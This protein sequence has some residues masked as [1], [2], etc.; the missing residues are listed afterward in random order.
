MR[1]PE[2]GRRRQLASLVWL[3]DTSE[4]RAGA[5]AALRKNE[6]EG[7]AERL[8]RADESGSILVTVDARGQ[9]VDVGVARDWRER[10]ELGRFAGALFEAYVAAVKASFERAAL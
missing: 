7:Q 6:D 8:E 4:L 1:M 5:E 10:L 9:V 3:G 2:G